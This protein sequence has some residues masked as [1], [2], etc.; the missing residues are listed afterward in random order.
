MKKRIYIKRLTPGMRSGEDIYLEEHLVLSR[1]FKLTDKAIEKLVECKIDSILV[2]IPDDE[3]QKF[4]QK[5]IRHEPEPEPEPEPKKDMTYAERLRAS[6]EFQEFQANYEQT[7]FQFTNTLNDIVEKNKQV[8]IE[9]MFTPAMNRLINGNN[10]SGI[11]D[12]LSNMRHYDDATYEHCLNVA[13]L[14]NILATWLKFS[15]DDIKLATACGLMHDIGKLTIP[16]EIVKKPGKLT[17]EE[18]TT[19][20]MHTVNGFNILKKANM[21]EDIQYAALHHHEKYDGSGYPHGL[22]GNDINRFGRLVAIADVYDAM[23]AERVYRGSLCPFKVISIFEEEGLQKYDT[24]YILTFLE[25]VV[26]TYINNNVRLSDGR[27]GK[28]VF[29]NRSRLSL[30]M[31]SIDGKVMNL[32]DEKGITI[33]EIL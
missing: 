5:P 20:K 28:V 32:A 4:V 17:P 31:V 14:S 7:I 15:E 9:E 22:S 24:E 21:D 12:I 2:D 25:K 3:A 1:G 26:D 23:T 18:Y 19:I 16:E 30:P 13:L 11:F 8:N 29:V 33:E 10:K 27:V 6:E